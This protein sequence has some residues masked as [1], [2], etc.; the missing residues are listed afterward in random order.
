[1]WGPIEQHLSP[2]APIITKYDIADLEWGSRRST[3]PSGVAPKGAVV[4]D[5]LGET[6]TTGGWDPNS[7]FLPVSQ[8]G[9]SQRVEDLLSI[10][11]GATALRG[12]S[13]IREYV[14]LLT[15]SARMGSNTP[16]SLAVGTALAIS[17]GLVAEAMGGVTPENRFLH[18]SVACALFL[19]PPSIAL[20]KWAL[21]GVRRLSTDS[22]LATLK[23]EYQILDR[24][25][26]IRD[27][28]SRPAQPR[29]IHFS[30]RTMEGSARVGEWYDLAFVNRPGS[31]PLLVVAHSELGK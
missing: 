8:E 17:Y 24:L 26:Q 14:S 30:Y 5:N 12:I 7:H 18:N 6:R 25:Q 27:A 11:S 4:F 9:V 20:V 31:S 1:M 15:V 10:S 22:V 16:E 2:G 3:L 23:P 21:R 13:Q 29:F 28:L 19:I